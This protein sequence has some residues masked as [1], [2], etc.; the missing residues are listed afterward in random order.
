MKTYYQLDDVVEDS[1]K[2][3][4]SNKT[5]KDG[6]TVIHVGS[7]PLILHGRT[8]LIKLSYV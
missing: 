6:D 5:L 8:N 4:K 2:I 1:V 3:L 7:S